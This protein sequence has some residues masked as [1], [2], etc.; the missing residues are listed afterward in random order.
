MYYTNL[1]WTG[2]A[3]GLLA[4][5]AAWFGGERFILR[6][7]R[8][9]LAATD[10]LAQG[11]LTSRAGLSQERGELGDLARKIDTMARPLSARW[12]SSRW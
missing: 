8:L 2:F 7:V 11:D 10:R 1:P 12:D 6:Q 3:V 5:S 9:L 4:L